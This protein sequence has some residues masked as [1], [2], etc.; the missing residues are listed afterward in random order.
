[1]YACSLWERERES[2]YSLS[3]STYI[4]GPLPPIKHKIINHTVAGKMDKR[5]EIQKILKSLEGDQVKDKFQ[6]QVK[7][8]K[9]RVANQWKITNDE[10][11]TIISLWS[12][13]SE[14]WYNPSCKGSTSCPPF[15]E[16]A[17]MYHHFCISLTKTMSPLP[18]AGD[19]KCF[20]CSFSS[21]SVDSRGVAFDK[22]SVTSSSEHSWYSGI[23]LTVVTCKLSGSRQL[24]TAPNRAS[25]FTHPGIR[26]PVNLNETSSVKWLQFLEMRWYV[27]PWYSA[28]I[29][30]IN[31]R[32]SKGDIL[33]C[34]KN[35]EHLY[36][37][38]GQLFGSTSKTPLT[39]KSWAPNPYSLPWTSMPEW[40]M[41]KPNQR[42]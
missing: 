39:G 1:M 10:L 3:G 21:I 13:H 36:K 33:M 41:P 5:T 2:S 35:M 19:N 8:Q 31:V 12:K 40:K 30:S 16:K 34:P 17:L 18:M 9:L 7:K 15:V 28:A 26:L 23:C 32:N 22:D 25:L 11:A 14:Q 38:P 4:N 20:S 6:L 42:V 27:S 37:K 24:H 29:F